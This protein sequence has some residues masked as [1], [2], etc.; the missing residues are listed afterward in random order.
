MPLP[1][2]D[3]ATI[4]PREGD[5]LPDICLPDQTGSMVDLHVARGGRRA[6]VVFHRSAEW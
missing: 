6:L 2:R 1:P 4:G 5:R 3:F